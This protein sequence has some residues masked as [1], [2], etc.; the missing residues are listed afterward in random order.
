M[1]RHSKKL[2]A[3]AALGLTFLGLGYFARVR[4]GLSN[5]RTQGGLKEVK[6]ETLPAAEVCG[7]VTLRKSR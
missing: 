2:E 1:N 5:Q 4:I 6:K 7:T 3:D